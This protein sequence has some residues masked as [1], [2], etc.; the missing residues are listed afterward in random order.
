M[1]RFPTSIA[2]FPNISYVF[3][4][5]KLINFPPDDKISWEPGSPVPYFFQ[6]V[7]KLFVP[8]KKKMYLKVTFELLLELRSQFE[9]WQRRINVS[10][11]LPE[12]LE[13]QGVK[14]VTHQA[15]F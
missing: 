1:I 8:V 10:S 12:E 15:L 14:I 4:C 5:F 11:A 6:P 9:R 2:I 13:A 7:Y 3:L